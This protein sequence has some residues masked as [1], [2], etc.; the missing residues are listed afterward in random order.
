MNASLNEPLL[1]VLSNHLV[2][3]VGVGILGGLLG[4]GLANFLQRYKR[5]PPTTP[6]SEDDSFERLKVSITEEMR[7]SFG[8]IKG[9]LVNLS[10]SMTEYVKEQKNRDSERAAIQEFLS[11][12]A[13][14]VQDIPAIAAT[15]IRSYLDQEAR[16]RVDEESK[17]QKDEAATKEE[18][19]RRANKNLHDN[20]M[21]RF[22]AISGPSTMFRISLLTGQI[23]KSLDGEST[24]KERLART[25][26][27][28]TNVVEQAGSLKEK[29]DSFNITGSTTSVTDHQNLIGEELRSLEKAIKD[30]SEAH[31]PVWFVSLMEEARRDRSLEGNI[32]ELRSLLGLEEVIVIPGDEVRGLDELDVVGAE[33]AGSKRVV[34]EL[35]ERGYRERDTGV[36]ICKPKVKVRLQG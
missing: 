10:S 36:V 4:F 13:R 34:S 17:R 33:G 8:D 15:Q 25:F 21:K 2:V 11:Q 29:L 1:L 26:A 5:I 28:Y 3:T 23:L 24:R 31:R 18:E 6:E 30:L 27:A 9:D 22:S 32:N 14:D 20:F 35:V 12:I 19:L 7:T 16:R